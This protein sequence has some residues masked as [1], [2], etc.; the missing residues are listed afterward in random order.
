M[1]PLF[2]ANK[3]YTLLPSCYAWEGHWDKKWWS[4]S[5][6]P[7]LSGKSQV[8][9]GP[10]ERGSRASYKCVSKTQGPWEALAMLSW[11]WAFAGIQPVISCVTRVWR[12]SSASCVLISC[13]CPL[14]FPEFSA[15]CRSH[16]SESPGWVKPVRWDGFR[17]RKKLVGVRGF[18]ENVGPK[19]QSAQ[20]AVWLKHMGFLCFE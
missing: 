16:Q 20:I 5:L 6:R 11:S 13:T 12:A 9:M 18:L 15:E 4:D 10:R 2:S 8:W 17:L 7:P 3:N 1:Y 14:I 19:P